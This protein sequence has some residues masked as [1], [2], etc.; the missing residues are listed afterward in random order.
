MKFQKATIKDIP[1]LCRIRKQQLIDEGIDPCID[2]DQ[3]LTRFF[4]D[5]FNNHN[6]VEY[7]AIHDN[8]I[9]AT[10]A[11]CFY[12]YPPTYTNQTGRIAYVTNMYTHPDYRKQGIATKIL[13]LLLEE[14]KVRHIEI[15]RLGASSLGKSVYEKF[16]FV[17]DHHWFHLN[18]KNKH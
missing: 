17:Q 9:I 2:I 8:Q 18:V 3:E 5:A 1:E 12:D 15:M 13:T 16:G 10:G 14:V 6:I 7:L 4:T 11:V